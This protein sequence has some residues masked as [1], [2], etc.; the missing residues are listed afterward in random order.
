MT[1]ED[2]ERQV[3]GICIAA[4]L[5]ITFGGAIV[6]AEATR[7]ILALFD[8]YEDEQW[9]PVTEPPTERQE[10]LIADE[11]K[12]GQWCIC[13]YYS[14]TPGNHWPPLDRFTGRWRAVALPPGPG[15]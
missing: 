10:V 11:M 12:D 15:E 14:F 4:S 13:M 1:R 9:R 3:S 7:Q 6:S 8:R 5:P 2:L